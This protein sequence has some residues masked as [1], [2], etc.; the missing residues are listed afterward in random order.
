M[1]ATFAGCIVPPAV[2]KFPTANL[3]ISCNMCNLPANF[4]FYIFWLRSSTFVL[5]FVLESMPSFSLLTHLPLTL[6]CRSYLLYLIFLLFLL[7]LSFP[8][9]FLRASSPPMHCFSPGF[10]VHYAPKMQCFI[11]GY[12]R[13]KQTENPVSSP[14]HPINISLKSAYHPPHLLRL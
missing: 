7:F 1:L 12:S 2:T 4:I 11:Y 3:G 13:I 6:S 10:F 8:T 5:G 9:R 14:L